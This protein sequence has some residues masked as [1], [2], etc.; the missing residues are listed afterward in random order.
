MV[1]NT[2]IQIFKNAELCIFRLFPCN[3]P[4]RYHKMKT[5]V[6][7]VVGCVSASLL[8]D[9]FLLPDGTSY[10]DLPGFDTIEKNLVHCKRKGGF[11]FT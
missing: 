8:L 4:Q 10:K 3:K 7:S 1:A 11:D 2:A 5:S 6:V 9:L